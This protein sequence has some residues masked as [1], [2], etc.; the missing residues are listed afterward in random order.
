MQFL[1]SQI[2]GEALVSVFKD[3]VPV[4]FIIIQCCGFS[5]DL[6]FAFLWTLLSSVSPSLVK[7]LPLP[8]CFSRFETVFL[9]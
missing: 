2:L 8:P 6:I 9:P 5:L 3:L 4:Q 1:G 7:D